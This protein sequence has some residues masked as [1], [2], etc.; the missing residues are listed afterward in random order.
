MSHLPPHDTDPSVVAFR[1]EVR[2][3]LAENWTAA[4]RQANR[5]RPYSDRNWDLAFSRKLGAQGWLGLEW[6]KAFGG[7]ARSPAERLAFIEEIEF[8]EAPVEGHAL[9]ENIVGPAI[10][11]HGSDEL[12]AEFLPAFLRGERPFA[13]HYS[14]P[15]AGS[16]L[17]SLRTSARRSGDDWIV[18]GQKLWTTFG[19][20]AE[21]AF[22]AV[23]TNPEAKPKH[24]GISVFLMPLDSPGITI[25]PSTAMYEGTFSATFYDEVKI[26]ARYMI[27]EENGGWRVITDAL[28]AER[29]LIGT[30]VAHVHHVFDQL[31][32]CVR[33]S[34]ALRTD[35]VVRDRIGGLAA[36]LEA[37][38]QFTL[39]N[40]QLVTEGR[41]P[42]YEAPMNK[43]FV[44][45]LQER[46]AEAA[47]DILGSGG[48]LSNEAPS[49]PLGG[50]EQELRR[51][52]MSV[53]GGGTGEIQ[54]NAIAMRGLGL[55]RWST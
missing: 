5:R 52:I 16:D 12:K 38:R 22:L 35:P 19:D 6:P 33:A 29:I 30:T 10:I 48:L 39:R 20:K 11:R 3:W 4:Q 31:T 24:A 1:Q 2:Q 53:L 42:V 26:P 43:V 47:L 7:Q 55:P 18:N 25:R 36:E 32:D 28:A 50:V 27:G 54:R 44:G 40:V 45:E 15:E 34:E 41:D 37:A 51:S 21:Y 8:A 13:L 9:A 23:R 17:A 14:E 49:A 46:L